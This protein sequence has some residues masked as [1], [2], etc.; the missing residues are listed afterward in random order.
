MGDTTNTVN[1]LPDY[2][3][4]D[5]VT[6]A[7]LKDMGETYGFPSTQELVSSYQPV[8]TNS[9]LA[10]TTTSALANTDEP[11]FLSELWGNTGK[12]DANGNYT[13]GS[14]VSGVL[15]NAGLM[16]SLTGLGS[17][18]LGLAN[19]FQNKGLLD[20]QKKGLEQ[21]IAFA[22]EDQARQRTNRQ[23]AANYEYRDRTGVA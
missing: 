20:L 22:N 4:K 15:N 5:Y 23:S 14:G 18:G 21:N 6:S 13:G 17:L 2:L 16:K 1:T 7:F 12:L 3:K 11:G 10:P 8:G 19:Y 9:V